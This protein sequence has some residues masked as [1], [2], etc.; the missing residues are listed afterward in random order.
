MRWLFVFGFCGPLFANSYDSVIPSSSYEICSVNSE[1]IEGVVSSSTGQVYISETDLHVR[2]AQ[3]ILL[4]RTYI[5]PQIEAGYRESPEA[6]TQASAQLQSKGWVVL[7]HLY[8][9]INQNSPYFQIR[10]PSGIVLEFE[11]IE[12]RGVLKTPLFGFSNIRGEKVSSAYDIRNIQLFVED[13]QVKVIWPDGITRIYVQSSF[14]NHMLQQEILPNGKSIRYEY[15]KQNLSKIYSCDRLGKYNYASIRK[16]KNNHYVGSNGL[17]ADLLYT[18]KEVQGD[19]HVKNVN[20][21]GNKRFS[22]PILIKSSNA[23]YSNLIDYNEDMLLSKYDAKAYPISFTYCRKTE[24]FDR[25]QIVSTPSGDIRFTY[26]PPIA[27]QKEGCTTVTH[28]NSSQTIYRYNKN[29]QLSGIENWLDNTLY[30]QKLFT[31]NLHQYISKIQVIDGNGEI[32]LTTH[33]ECDTAGNPILERV[34]GDF[35]TR[36]TKRAY[37]NNR[38]I[39]EENDDGLTIEYTYLGDTRLPASKTTL[40]NDLPIQKHLYFYDEACNLIKETEEGKSITHYHLFQKGSNLHRVEIVEQFDWNE[41]LISKKQFG[42][43]RYGNISSE[44]HFGTDGKLAFQLKKTYDSKGN[45][46]KESNPLGQVASYKYDTRS[47]QTQEVPFSGRLVIDKTYDAKGRLTTLKEGD[48]VTQYSYNSSDHVIEKIDYLGLKTLTTY[49]PLHQKPI[50]I[51]S[52]PTQTKISYD[53]FGRQSELQDAYGAITKTTYNSLG[54]P[55]SIQYPD[56][57][58]SLFSYDSL[59]RLI[60][61]IDCDG[62]KITYDYD[63][64]SRVLSKVVGSRTSVY[65]YDAYNLLEE[66]DALGF[67]TRYKY[68]LAGKVTEKNY[69]GRI[70]S[71]SYDEL[72]YL[73]SEE[74][75]GRITNYHNDLLGRVIQKSIDSVLSTSYSYDA[76]GNI[77]AIANEHPTT[78]SYDPYNRLVEKVDAEGFVTTITY[79]E[80]D[81]ILIKKITDSSKRTRIE[82]YNAH[83]LIIEKEV[84]GATVERFSYDKALRLASHDQ[85]AFTYTKEG[86][87]STMKDGDLDPI[88]WVYTPGGKVKMKTNPD[89]TTLQYEYSTQGELESISDRY[90]H[91]DG[92]GRLIAGSGFVRKLDSFGNIL[93]E[94]FSTGLFIESIYDQWDRPIKR[95]FPDS[96]TVDYE[97][98]GPFLKKIT[99]LMLNALEPY[100]HTYDSF[101]AAGNILSESSWFT[102]LYTYDKNGR[103]IY[104]KG[105]YLNEAICYDPAGNLIQSGDHHY[106]YDSANRLTAESDQ[107]FVKYDPHQHCIEKFGIP[108]NSIIFDVNGNVK[109]PGFIYDA[110]AQLVEANGSV[111]TYDALGRRLKQ[112]GITY[113]YIGDEEIGS[114]QDGKAKELKILGS[115]NPISIEIHTTPYL[116]V[117]DVQG[118]I[119][120]LVEWESGEIVFENNCDAFGE[121]LNAYTPYAYLGKRFDPHT[122]LIYFGKRFYDPSIVSW[123]TPDPLGSIDHSNLY[124]YV[125]NNPLKY[126][127]PHK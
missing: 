125:F 105:P 86:R 57:G 5:S 23:F 54:I 8:A 9:G 121:W 11:I 95:T 64:L 75:D 27:G 97:Y 40:V 116:P 107:F 55:V 28:L 59:G 81:Q 1:L 3:D 96:S 101:D 51:E 21:E 19:Y 33:Y 87:I 38:L 63:S 89:G 66:I 74:R 39:W 73:A 92:I 79:E 72:G 34:E 126:Q 36:S 127:R 124:Q 61:S 108:I 112:D 111:N 13:D 31:Y 103:Q 42:Y 62:L 94:E 82:A 80:S 2:G 56:G 17:S 43:D 78:Y 88:A 37:S 114:Y 115:S 25:V 7:P 77:A 122:R 41:K 119:R 30:N 18:I 47:R 14:G 91:Y 45:L 110:F 120:L 58:T 106:T 29:L 52:N 69:E 24:N 85:L 53:W 49:H 76:A 67:S 35:G 104:Q 98:E 68:N 12:N 44:T 65:L 22:F 26:D 102:T 123:L 117:I 16:G 84:P 90:F 71:F 93:K 113:L 4:K 100:T 15:Y 99:R 50:L 83:G 46:L 6:L 48:H 60:E 32:Q 118:T 109:K 10:D 70:S 20:V